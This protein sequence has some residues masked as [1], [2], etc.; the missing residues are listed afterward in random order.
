MRKLA[1]GIA[2]LILWALAGAAL[3]YLIVLRQ[4]EV[5]TLF[6]T[7]VVIWGMVLACLLVLGKG[8]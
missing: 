7:C 6:G 1:F 5:A 4:Y 2:V 8:E 3:F